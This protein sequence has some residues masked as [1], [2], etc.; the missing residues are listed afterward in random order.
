MGLLQWR[1]AAEGAVACSLIS[2]T[3]L[4]RRFP[5]NSGKKVFSVQASTYRQLFLDGPV[6]R[7]PTTHCTRSAI[8][9]QNLSQQP[10]SGSAFRVL[11]Y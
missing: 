7:W 10:A 3:R 1:R 2:R 8:F 6:G 4:R 11:D 5:L 9:L